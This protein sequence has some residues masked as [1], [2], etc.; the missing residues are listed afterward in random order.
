M[1]RYVTKKMKRKDRKRKDRRKEERKKKED[2]E[3]DKSSSFLL[4]DYFNACVEIYRKSTNY[5]RIINCLG[6]RL[7]LLFKFG[8]PPEHRGLSFLYCTYLRKLSLN[9]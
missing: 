4:I 3:E 6:T 7:A 9:L 1:G 5:T 2:E 8:I